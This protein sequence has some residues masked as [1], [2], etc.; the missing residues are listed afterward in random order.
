MRS[1]AITTGGRRGI[2]WQPKTSTGGIQLSVS[3][4]VPISRRMT[5][6]SR[7]DIRVS[8]RP[9]RRTRSS[10]RNTQRNTL[11]C[12]GRPY[13]FASLCISR[14]R[15]GSAMS[16]A[17]IYALRSLIVYRTPDRQEYPPEAL[18]PTIVLE[19]AER[20]DS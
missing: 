3:S 20:A 10:L 13:P 19:H 16:Y 8:I 5:L 6:S 17:R 9:A 4:T 15:L 7:C 18:A 1:H 11:N 12:K 2:S 14:S